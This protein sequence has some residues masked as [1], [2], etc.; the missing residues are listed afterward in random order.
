ML[1]RG[2]PAQA[3]TQG[4]NGGASQ[5]CPGGFPGALKAVFLNEVQEK[6]ELGEWNPVGS[7]GTQEYDEYDINEY[8]N[9]AAPLAD[10]ADALLDN[11]CGKWLIQ[12][13]GGPSAK[14]RAAQ[15][16]TTSN[17][18][19]REAGQAAEP[20]LIADLTGNGKTSVVFPSGSGIEVI[21]LGSDNSVLTQ[22]Q[23][24]TGF[25]PDSFLSTIVTADFNG[26]G[27]A[28][29]AV[30]DPGNPGT[31]NGGVAILLG[32]GDG[33][34]QTATYFAAGQ[35]PSSLAAGD[36]NGDGKMDLAAASSVAGSILV[37]P[38]NGDGTFGTAATYPNG[39]DSQAVPVSIAAIDLNGDGRPDL[40]VANRGFA[41]VP[42]SSISTLL[43][44][45]SG[46]QPKFNAP[47]SLA[48]LPSFLAWSDL[49]NDGNTDL[50]VVSASASAVITLF[51]KGDGTFQ[52]PVAYAAGN[53]AGTGVILPLS[54]GSSLMATPDI[55]YN[56][57]WFSSVSPQGVLGAPILNMVGGAPTGIA[58]ADL[59]GDGLP[60]AVVSGGSSDVEVLEGESGGLF[61][62]PVG[63]SLAQP[64]PMPQAV[65]IG[66]LNNDGNPDVVVASAAGLVS[67]L[68]GNSNGTLK[69]PINIQVSQGAQSIALADFNRDG[70]L[71]AVV[72]A[73][74]NE[75]GAGGGGVVV[76]LGN[77]DGTFQA[78]PALALSGFE[79]SAVAAGDLNG[80]GIPDLAVVMLS[81]VNQGTAMLAVFLG[82]G[83]GAFQSPRTFPLKGPAASLTGII[84]NLSGIVI[85]DWNGDGKPDIAAG[86]QA[87][88]TSLDILLGDGTG[89]FVEVGTLPATEDEPIY[90]ATADINQDG[91]LDLV[92]AHCC[93]QND[94]TYLL[95]NGDGTFNTENQLITGNSP[96]AVAVTTSGNTATVFSADNLAAAVTAVSLSA[97]ASITA[98]VSAASSTIITLAPASIATMFG[99]N[100]ATSTGDAT[101]STLPTNL[102]GTTVSITDSSGAEQDAPLF[103]VSPTQVNYLVPANTA[104]GQA[105]V[106]VTN[107]E[108]MVGVTTSQ[109]TPVAP[110]IFELDASGLAAAIVLVVA[111]D[112]SQKFQNV[113]EVTSPNTLTPLPI[114]LSA[115]EVYL[116]LY[117]TGIRNANNV[118]VTVGGGTV[119]V[120]SSGAQ[121]IFLGLDQID[122]GPLPASLAGKGN[123]NIALTADGQT[124]NTINVTIQ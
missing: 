79:P 74:G 103:Y 91:I 60:D 12:L 92:V 94:A 120:L 81:G 39:G 88:Q 66:D 42:N 48:L 73:F 84:G 47:L 57:I 67:A 89:N 44:T 121:G 75:G 17:A 69:A 50:A 59:N 37:L 49:N 99:S 108:G 43:N 124:A 19:S 36:F 35:N 1:A 30:S 24:A 8:I 53:S 27:K 97:S 109:I 54:D 111:P 107:S 5:S 38:G 95:G 29:L 23:F 28:D 15:R 112:G 16:A 116:E 110:G 56:H 31:S 46:L 86:S 70:K 40:A 61:K 122:V 63:Y 102:K 34:F 2:V 10:L 4:A 87:D 51:G 41:T 100:L 77:G 55:V 58:V 105:V 119:P 65:A 21:V 80:D 3:Q 64:S 115:G 123:V 22:N 13:A 90:L 118:T 9:R 20:F 52:A 96:A 33:T 83:D 101:T 25:T 32:N 98:N 114:N 117:G 18:A 76:L 78:Q 45:G 113:Y 106:T 82:N 62:T 7:L 71:D 14:E 93:G 68:L 6:E 85:G 26:D 11:P 72:A 104:A